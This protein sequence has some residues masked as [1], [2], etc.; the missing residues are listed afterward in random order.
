MAIK[1]LKTVTGLMINAENLLFAQL[2]ERKDSIF[3]DKI[4][5]FSTPPHSFLNGKIK[6]PETLSQQILRI[7]T[8][9]GFFS[10]N[11]IVAFSDST[12]IKHIDTFP[13]TSEYELREIIEDKIISNYTFIEEEVMFGYQKLPVE[14]QHKYLENIQILYAFLSKSKITAVKELLESIDLNLFAIDLESLAAVRAVSANKY[15][16]NS[17]VL[18][19]YIAQDYVDFNILKNGEIIYTYSI[20][21]DIDKVIS[22]PIAIEEFMQRIKNFIL[23]YENKYPNA[24]IDKIL[25]ISNKE[26]LAAFLDEIKNNFPELEIE[27]YNLSEANFPDIPQIIEKQGIVENINSFIVPI[28]LGLKFFENRSKTLSLIKV[29]TQIEPIINKKQLTICLASLIILSLAFGGGSFYLNMKSK[30]F[31]KKLNQIKDEIRAYSTGE[32]IQR[33]RELELL[34]IKIEKYNKFRDEQISRAQF[35]Q[36]LTVNLADDITFDSL[37]LT[38]DNKTTLKGSAYLPNSIYN[39]YKYLV[40]LFQKVEIQK[41]AIIQRPEEVPQIKWEIA[42]QWGKK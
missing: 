39:L 1:T 10:N 24:A 5:S 30:A 21:R 16:D 12:F 29:K 9:E 18:S 31:D 2:S 42:F 26:S 11:I 14:A 13:N 4:K 3:I 33:Q 6:D 23:A 35:L 15:L 28:G 20:K 22:N 17:E 8:E 40:T 32:F 27:R 34:R 41:L 25:V 38:K 7:L 19:V 37:D 36:N